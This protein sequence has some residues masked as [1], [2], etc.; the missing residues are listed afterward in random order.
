MSH[1]VILHGTMTDS[2]LASVSSGILQRGDGSNKELAEG[3]RLVTTLLGTGEQREV[4]CDARCSGTART[5]PLLSPSC[6]AAA[7]N[8]SL[9]V[10]DFNLIRKVSPEGTVTIVARLK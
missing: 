8:G 4:S 3:S 10:G 7:P 6:L 9:Y 1:V 2:F 5:S